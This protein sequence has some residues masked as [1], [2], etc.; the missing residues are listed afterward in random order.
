M[1]SL[2]LLCECIACA[3][4]VSLL[5]LAHAAQEMPEWER[6]GN[7][8]SRKRREKPNECPDV[9]ILTVSSLCQSLPA[10]LSPYPLTQKPGHA[11]I[12]EV[13]VGENKLFFPLW[14]MQRLHGHEERGAHKHNLLKL[15]LSGLRM[16]KHLTDWAVP[17]ELKKGQIRI[18]GRIEHVSLPGQ[19]WKIHYTWL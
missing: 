19:F 10:L 17:K 2:L 9:L 6:W 16:R 13:R 3:L 7:N 11:P 4:S 14:G 12:L 8:W 15:H 18:M 5:R 1:T